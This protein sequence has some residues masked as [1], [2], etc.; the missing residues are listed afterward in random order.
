MLQTKKLRGALEEYDLNSYRA[1]ANLLGISKGAASMKM[2]GMTQ[3]KAS[4]IFTIATAC[5]LF[6]RI[7]EIF[8]AEEKE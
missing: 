3:F 4:E 5:N 1:V 7:E 8:F 2:R 6:G